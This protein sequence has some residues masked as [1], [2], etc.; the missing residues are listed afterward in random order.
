MADVVGTIFNLTPLGMAVNVSRTIFNT[1]G[2]VLGGNMQGAG[3]AIQDGFNNSPI[4][5]AAQSGV[6]AGAANMYPYNMGQYSPYMGSQQNQGGSLVQSYYP[7]GTLGSQMRT[8]QVS[9]HVKG[10]YGQ[11]GIFGDVFSS[12]EDKNA[13]QTVTNKISGDLYGVNPQVVNSMTPTMA[14]A[15]AKGMTYDEYTS[16]MFKADMSARYPGMQ[17]DE[18]SVWYQQQ[19]QA[20]KDKAMAKDMQAMGITDKNQFEAMVDLTIQ[21]NMGSSYGMNS[22]QNLGLYGMNAQGVYSADDVLAAYKLGYAEGVTSVGK[23]KEEAGVEDEKESEE[24]TKESEEKDEKDS[25]EK[26]DKES[27][28]KTDNS[29][30]KDDKE[31][32]SK[33]DTS[34]EKDDKESESK[35]DT[36]EEKDDKESESKTDNSEEKDDKESESKTDTSEEKDDK[37]SESK[38]DNSEEKDD[39]ESESKT[40]TSEEKDD[41]ESE[42]KTDTSEEKDDKESESKTDTSEDKDNKESESK[43]DAAESLDN[44]ETETETDLDASDSSSSS[45]DS[46]SSGD[47]QQQ[48]EN[49]PEVEETEENTEAETPHEQG[50]DYVDEVAAEEEVES[51]DSSNAGSNETESDDAEKTDED[52]SDTAEVEEAKENTGATENTSV[53]AGNVSDSSDSSS[54]TSETEADKSQVEEAGM[55]DSADN[56]SEAEQDAMDAVSEGIS[57]G[58]D[59]AKTE[60]S[61][62]N[63]LSVVGDAIDNAG[64]DKTSNGIDESLRGIKLSQLSGKSNVSEETIKNY[65]DAAAALKEE[66]QSDGAQNSGNAFDFVSDIAS[67]AKNAFA[68]SAKELG[69]AVDAFMS[70]NKDAATPT[71]EKDEAQMGN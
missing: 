10:M 23:A 25:E 5:I 24:D 54:S 42:S 12:Q 44:A 48:E 53:E 43:S 67:G 4:G 7:E 56:T 9:Q 46:S 38:T 6:L 32:E 8:N 35:T 20:Y 21:N 33:I 29:E 59:E 30:E 13:A 55:D 28:S 69:G 61:R 62:F 58:V 31:S 39:K 16:E 60:S 50:D 47:S 68:N 2:N 1:A 27:E 18:N 37:E 14:A 22:Q 52:K 41:K 11:D 40:D 64:K 70:A 26:D 15:G 45:S 71:A 51:S 34:E 57:D 36:S 19:E 49:G 3:E 63:P 65:E 17:F 66:M